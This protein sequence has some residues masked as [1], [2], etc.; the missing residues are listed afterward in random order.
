M[1]LQR[2]QKFLS[3]TSASKQM[4]LAVVSL[5][6][7]VWVAGGLL[8]VTVMGTEA[9][10]QQQQTQAKL[11]AIHQLVPADGYDNHPLEYAD[12]LQNKT[13][14]GLDTTLAYW[15]QKNDQDVA[16]IVP[17]VAPNGYSGDIN[18]LVAMTVEDDPKLI[19]I[20]V[21]Q[22]KETP[23][24]GDKI[25]TKKSDWIQSF[26]NLDPK[27]VQWQV[28]KDGG[29]FDQFTG[30]TITPRAIVQATEKAINGMIPMIQQRLNNRS[31]K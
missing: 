4:L 17:V 26:A 31:K 29:Q 14:S 25:E 10:I 3:S 12:I 13:W 15:F 7:V 11:R 6:V 1:L 19:G 8:I 21:T 30:A 2:W 27:T 16:L 22:H 9:Q 20:R 23:G 28:K 24:L 18:L 5:L